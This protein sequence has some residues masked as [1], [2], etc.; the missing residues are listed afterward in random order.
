MD[1]ISIAK[2][3]EKASAEPD[4]GSQALSDSVE[5]IHKKNIIVAFITAFLI[6]FGIGAVITYVVSVHWIKLSEEAVLL[7][8]SDETVR[9]L[10]QIRSMIHGLISGKT[11][12]TSEKIIDEKASI[13]FSGKAGAAQEIKNG[14]A[15][16][17][18][19]KVYIH[20]GR[21]EDKEMAEAFS[22]LLRNRGYASVETEK[23][24]HT[25]RD[26]RYFHGEDKKAALLLQKQLKEFVASSRN[27]KKF[28]MKIKNLG[29][30][31]P[32]AQK[33]SLEVWVFF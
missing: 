1:K 27:A 26:I 13:T 32:R 29:S 16:V 30:S 33:G 18:G 31:Y 20:Y 9:E 6:G 10:K 21:D 17:G 4:D 2:R 25:S 14:T 15:S 12:N 22:H 3:R 24:Q 19:N 5:Y 23:I 8:K 11:S 7:K 28:T